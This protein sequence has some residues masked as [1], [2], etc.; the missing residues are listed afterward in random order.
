MRTE[1][2]IGILSGLILL[3]TAALSSTAA[4]ADDPSVLSLSVRYVQSDL[5]NPAAAE[6]LYKRI[7]HAARIVC[8]E[9]DVRELDRFPVYKECYARAV[10]TAVANVGATA[11]TAVHRSHGHT[12]AAG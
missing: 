8:R 3:G 11:L 2:R 6:K 1:R 5:Q 7:E 12:Q 10:D 9:P 4:L